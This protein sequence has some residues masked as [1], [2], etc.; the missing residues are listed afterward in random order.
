MASASIT[1]PIHRKSD[2][3]KIFKPIA[4]FDIE[5]VNDMLDAAYPSMTQG[6]FSDA[7]QHFHAAICLITLVVVKRQSEVAKLLQML[8]VCREYLVGLGLQI[9]MKATQ[10]PKRSVELA[11]YF[12]HCTL[13]DTHSQ[14]IVQQAM[15]MAFKLKCYGTALGFARRL[16]ALNPDAK[17]AETVRKF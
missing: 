9:S 11:A 15:V 10:D 5:S 1:S 6:R 8:S 4:I 7:Q 2:D 14:K 17:V 16:L 12:T 13:E 3:T